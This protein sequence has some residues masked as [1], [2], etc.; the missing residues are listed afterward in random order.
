MSQSL[1][2]DDELQAAAG[3]GGGRRS[4]RGEPRLQEL[5]QSD[6]GQNSTF[7]HGHACTIALTTRAQTPFQNRNPRLPPPPRRRR[8]PATPPLL[9]SLHP[10]Q[11]VRCFGPVAPAALLFRIQWCSACCFFWPLAACSYFQSSSRANQR[12]MTLPRMSSCNPSMSP[13]P[14]IAK[15]ELAAVAKLTAGEGSNGAMLH[16]CCELAT[17]FD[18][19]VVGFDFRRGRVHV[20]YRRAQSFFA[21]SGF[22]LGHFVEKHSAAKR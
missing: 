15:A 1:R 9:Q 5:L 19:P 14:A 7:V 10:A 21:K 16:R 11:Q 4:V 22:V 2:P 6:P 17:D 12:Q 8:L 20:R 3:R 13:N 18:R